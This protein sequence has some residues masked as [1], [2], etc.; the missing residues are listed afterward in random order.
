MDVKTIRLPVKMD[1]N[2]VTG[3]RKYTYE[4][5]PVEAVEKLLLKLKSAAQ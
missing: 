5:V 4:E 2:L 1:Y 3:E